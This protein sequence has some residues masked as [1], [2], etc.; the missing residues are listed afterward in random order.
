MTPE[1]LIMLH[2]DLPYDPQKAHEYYLRTRELKGRSK[3]ADNSSDGRSGS[4]SGGSQSAHRSAKPKKSSKQRQAEIAALAA[5]LDKKLARLKKALAV[6]VEQAKGRS[7]VD[8]HTDKK[9]T[10]SPKSSS[11]TTHRTAAQKSADAKRS[12]EYQEKHKNDPKTNKYV[13]AIRKKI[14]EVRKKISDLREEIAAAAEKSNKSPTS[15]KRRQ[16]VDTKQ[17]GD[18]QNG[19]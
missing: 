4:K 12:K 13:E 14:E 6:L 1:E 16:A 2:A 5:A 7:G 19:S 9:N 18:S 3:G 11:E 17:K 15:P 10:D 8:P